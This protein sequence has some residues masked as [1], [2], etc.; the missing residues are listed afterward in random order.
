MSAARTGPSQQVIENYARIWGLGLHTARHL[1]FLLARHP[2]L[3]VTSGRRTA[4]E[5]RRVGGVPDSFHLRG[6]AVDMVAPLPVLLDA[7]E[8][9][10][11]MRV[12]RTC[13]GP[14]EVLLEYPRTRRQ[15]LHVAW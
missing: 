1:A 14:E 11:E 3:V 4:A 12:S 7:A 10:K 13:T 5:N 9:A 8:T 15:H 6:R 2:G